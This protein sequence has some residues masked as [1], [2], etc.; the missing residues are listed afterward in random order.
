M[1]PVSLH[2][3]KTTLLLSLNISKLFVKL[4]NLRNTTK[5]RERMSNYTTLSCKGRAS[6]SP[7]TRGTIC[8]PLPPSGL[9]SHWL[10]GTLGSHRSIRCRKPAALPGGNGRQMVPCVC[11]EIDPQPCSHGFQSANM[12][13]LHPDTQI[14]TSKFQL[15]KISNSGRLAVVDNSSQIHKTLNCCCCQP[16]FIRIKARLPQTLCISFL[17]Y[18]S[19]INCAPCN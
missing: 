14:L 4:T 17:P 8:L 10:H 12:Q 11:D 15:L 9:L 3:C 16:R 5:H 7:L 6:A 1:L 13:G 19:S 2:S 18:R